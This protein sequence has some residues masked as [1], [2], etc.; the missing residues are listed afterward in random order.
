MHWPHS[1][2]D[3]GIVNIIAAAV[4]MNIIGYLMKTAIP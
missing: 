1:L 3:I 2:D 4:V